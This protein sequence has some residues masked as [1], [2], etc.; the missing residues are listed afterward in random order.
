[1]DADA[2]KIYFPLFK[3]ENII[4]LKYINILKSQ[5]KPLKQKSIKK[6]LSH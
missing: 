2:F 4:R 6:N 1:M 5:L 3:W